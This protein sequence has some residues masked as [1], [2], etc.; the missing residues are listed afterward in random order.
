[1]V[2]VSDVSSGRRGGGTDRRMNL[3]S[4]TNIIMAKAISE[5]K[6]EISS[7]INRRSWGIQLN[8]CFLTTMIAETHL[9]N[10]R[11]QHQYY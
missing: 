9:R 7:L 3:T 11:V 10:L 4:T 5:A 2:G 1:M 8:D 6:N